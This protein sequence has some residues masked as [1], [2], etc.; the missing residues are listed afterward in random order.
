MD[1][2]IKYFVVVCASATGVMLRNIITLPLV[3]HCYSYWFCLPPPHLS[4]WMAPV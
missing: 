4:D 1:S 2:H 3:Q